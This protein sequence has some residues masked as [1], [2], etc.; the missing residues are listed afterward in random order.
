MARA[1]P[2]FALRPFVPGD[3]P[4]LADIFSASIEGL[5]GEDYS[6][7]QVDAWAAAAE[8]ED[9]FEQKLAKRLTL[10]ATM[11]GAPVGFAA[12]EEPGRVDLLYVHP[13]VAGRGVGTMLLDALEKLATARGAAK[14]TA[15]VSDNAQEFFA[16]HGFKAQQRNSVPL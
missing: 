7:S 4:V 11:E 13:A 14:L 2:T 8:D 6:P 10:V 16:K 15:D 12:L 9:A 3:V 5:A 1:N